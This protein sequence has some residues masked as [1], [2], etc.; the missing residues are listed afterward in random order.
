V[1]KENI[2]HQLLNLPDE[3]DFGSTDMRNTGKMLRTW[4]T[5]NL[6]VVPGKKTERTT[7]SYVRIRINALKKKMNYE[8]K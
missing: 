6:V 3:H 8:L 7:K 4:R 2:E 1:F 5:R